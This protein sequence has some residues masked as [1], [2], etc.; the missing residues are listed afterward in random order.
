MSD[1]NLADSIPDFDRRK[2]LVEQK[3]APLAP[4]GTDT[5]PT[6]IIGCRNVDSDSVPDWL[7]G[8]QRIPTT[9]DSLTRCQVC[10]D[11]VWIGPRQRP[12]QSTGIR[13]CQL[14]IGVATVIGVIDPDRDASM[15]L[16]RSPLGIPRTGPT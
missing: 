7:H 4:G 6:A 1:Q 15:T 14:C 16:G 13:V 8:R 3:L 12:I 11:Q 10:G 5:R 9:A 2:A